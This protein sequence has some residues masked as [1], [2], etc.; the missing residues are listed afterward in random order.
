MTDSLDDRVPGHS[1]LRDTMINA[2]LAGISAVPLVGGVVAQF[3]SGL[4]AERQGARQHKFNVAVAR[5]VEDV[6]TRVD[7]LTPEAVLDSDEF[8]AAYE[9]ASRAAAETSS[10]EKRTRLASAVRHAGP[11]STIDESKRAQFLTLVARYDDLH[12]AM[13]NFFRDPR[14]WIKASTADWHE[15]AQWGAS[16]LGALLEKYVFPS[17][18]GWR[19]LVTPVLDE[20]QNAG[21]LD[22]APLNTMMTPSGPLQQRTKPLG[23]ELLQFVEIDS[24]P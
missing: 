18:A 22:N 19:Q 17:V 5:V 3:T 8:M 9:R 13:L 6:L 2:G 20:L 7:G 12:F 21:L 16:S 10:A 11:W 14:A 15:P 23:V 1:P 4:L 24:T